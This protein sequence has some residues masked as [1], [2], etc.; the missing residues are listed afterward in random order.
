MQPLVSMNATRGEK[1]IFWD[2]KSLK[3]GIFKGSAIPKLLLLCCC[4][5]CWK[6]RMLPF[7]VRLN[8]SRQAFAITGLCVLCLLTC[9][10]VLQSID[11]KISHLFFSLVAAAGCCEKLLH[12]LWFFLCILSVRIKRSVATLISN[13]FATSILIGQE[14]FQEALYSRSF[15]SNI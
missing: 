9:K 6:I 12:W 3:A 10:K 13:Y 14:A 5:C 1:C 8:G 15:L 7:T 11:G 4:Y 2:C